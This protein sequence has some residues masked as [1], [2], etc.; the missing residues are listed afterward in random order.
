M[1]LLNALGSAHGQHNSKKKTWYPDEWA[2]GKGRLDFASFIIK[3][4]FKLIMN[5]LRKLP[6][7]SAC[8]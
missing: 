1:V 6:K 7:F 3:I 5:Y 2:K 4:F 8:L